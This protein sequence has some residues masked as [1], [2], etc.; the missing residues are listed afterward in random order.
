MTELRRRTIEDMQLAG[1]SRGTQDAYVGVVR[2]PDA[3]VESVKR[4][5]ARRQDDSGHCCAISPSPSGCLSGAFLKMRFIP[6]D[7]PPTLPIPSPH[8]QSNRLWASAPQR[9]KP[10]VL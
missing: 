1:L 7:T 8:A 3:S 6:L 9:K 5:P 4:I 2:P 10:F